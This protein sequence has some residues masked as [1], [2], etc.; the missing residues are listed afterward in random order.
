[1]N[2]FLCYNKWTQ[3]IFPYLDIELF[4][5]NFGCHYLTVAY[6]K[7]RFKE[8]QKLLLEL[9]HKVR[10]RDQLELMGVITP[11][12]RDVDNPNLEVRVKAIQTFVVFFQ[13]LSAVVI[14]LGLIPKLMALFTTK[15]PAALK[16]AV[17]TLM[18]KFSGSK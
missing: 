15:Q 18:A 9:M 2:Q 17:A 5:N 6:C 16:G 11:L 8:D 1:V 14:K 3:L 12:M 13:A 4:K 10:P 7:A